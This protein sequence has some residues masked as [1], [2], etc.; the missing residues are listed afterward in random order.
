MLL[1]HASQPFAPHADSAGNAHRAV[2]NEQLSVVARHEPEPTAKSGGVEHGGLD[3]ALSDTAN[4]FARRSA[5]ADPV[6]EEADLD[7]PRAGFE[8][9]VR[10]SPT[11][12]IG[13]EDIALQS[14]TC[15]RALDQG[16]HRLERRRAVAQQLYAVAARDVSRCHAPQ[17]A[18]KGGPGNDGQRRVAPVKRELTTWSDH[19]RARY[20]NSALAKSLRARNPE[21]REIPNGAKCHTARNPKQRGIPEGGHGA[22]SQTARSAKA[23]LGPPSTTS[24]AVR[25]AI[26]HLVVSPAAGRP[27]SYSARLL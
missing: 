7:P 22:E 12:L 10:K 9:G 11:D 25:A 4:E 17:S 3:T 5:A 26:D 15:A 23:R 8:Q 6:E 19:H 18:R 24:W 16:Q 13:A 2:D 21:R 27:E 20:S 1:E 14:D